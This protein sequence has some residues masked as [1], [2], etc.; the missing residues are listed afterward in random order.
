MLAAR[1]RANGAHPLCASFR[2]G[3]ASNLG[4]TGLSAAEECRYSTTSGALQSYSGNPALRKPSIISFKFFDSRL[5]AI[6]ADI[7][8][9][10]SYPS[11]PAAASRAS[12]L[13]PRWRKRMRGSDRVL[14][15]RGVRPGFQLGDPNLGTSVRSTNASAPSCGRSSAKFNAAS[16][17]FS[18]TS[19]G[20]S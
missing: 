1:W 13:H 6:Y 10:G 16:I 2:Y 12:A 8:K 5:R 4:L 14:D 18:Q 3:Y 15:G 19:R 20:R 11:T 17:L 7:V 9:A